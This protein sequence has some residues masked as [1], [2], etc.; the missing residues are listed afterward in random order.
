MDIP[1]SD[2]LETG[3]LARIFD[4]TAESYKFF[5]FGA[6]LDRII[7]GCDHAVFSELVDDMIARH[8]TWSA[9]IT[10]PLGLQIRWKSSSWSFAIHALL[11]APR[12]RM[13]LFHS[14]T[15]FQVGTKPLGSDAG[16]SR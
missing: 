14:E 13:S 10:S 1:F 3:K 12:K 8:G 4:S 15:P 2:K 16:R 11:K 5:W 7:S 6:V 9:S